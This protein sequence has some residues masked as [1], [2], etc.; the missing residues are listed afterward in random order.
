[1]EAVEESSFDVDSRQLR[2][3]AA[4]YPNRHVKRPHAHPE[5]DLSY[6]RTPA[7]AEFRR[8]CWDECGH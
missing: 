6:L 3:L 4:G 8:H 5:A 2:T 1:L 7:G